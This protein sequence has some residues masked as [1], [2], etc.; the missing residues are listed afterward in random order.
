MNSARNVRLVLFSVMICLTAHSQTWNSTTA[1]ASVWLTM[2]G[3]QHG[4]NLV[5]AAYSDE[6]FTFP[7]LIYASTNGGQTWQP[8]SAPSNFWFS[9]AASADGQRLIAGAYTDAAGSLGQIFISTNGSLTWAVCGDAP[10]KNWQAVGS[11]A[12]GRILVGATYNNYIYVSTN[13]GVNWFQS[14]TINDWKTLA[15]STNGMKMYAATLD[16]IYLSTNSGS[17]WN[18]STTSPALSYSVVC[19]ADGNQIFTGIVGGSGTTDVGIYSSTNGGTTWSQTSAPIDIFQNYFFLSMSTY[20][21]ILLAGAYSSENHG[22][23]YL[24]TD[25][26]STWIPQT[27]PTNSWG[28]VFCSA[29]G[30]LLT[31]G[32]FSGAI[33][34]ASNP[35]VKPKLKITTAANKSIVSWPLFPAGF[36]LQSASS[37]TSS[38]NWTN[39]VS[40]AVTLGTNYY[41]TNSLASPSAFFRLARP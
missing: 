40:S 14:A 33:Y 15:V 35:L 20:G 24:S 19:S 11:S 3:S 38:V 12:D 2:A 22:L 39:A 8:T 16:G 30:T 41:S 9:V 37:L 13:F 5:A 36:Q 26:G 18:F 7:G 4:S 10:L 25:G 21:D 6:S 17:S 27:A 34:S 1:P 32:E 23:V 29:D 31:A 28:C